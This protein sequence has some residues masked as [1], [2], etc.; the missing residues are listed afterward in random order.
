MF[1]LQMSPA[2]VQTLLDFF[3][4]RK[5]I[6]L[7]EPHT[8]IEVQ[9]TNFGLYALVRWYYY[10][11]NMTREELM[12]STRMVIIL[13]IMVPATIHCFKLCLACSCISIA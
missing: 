7:T 9:N 8:Q 2:T 3:G 12:Y 4:W 6:V 1:P 5:A 11:T 13:G 10:V